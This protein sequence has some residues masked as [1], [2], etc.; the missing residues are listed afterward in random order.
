MHEDHRD[1][2]VDQLQHLEPVQLGHL[3]VEE[4]HVGLVFRDGLHG[5]EAV[6]ALADDGDVFRGIRELAQDGTGKVFIVDNHGSDHRARRFHR[7][8]RPR[9]AVALEIAQV[10][11]QITRG[12][13]TAL[14]IFLQALANGA[15]ELGWQRVVEARHGFGLVIQN[16][17]I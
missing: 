16:A 15:F 9:T 10:H 17:Q 8:H 6:G 12:L 7:T 4:N 14:A 5:L 2:V 3:H 1:I 11:H 13:I